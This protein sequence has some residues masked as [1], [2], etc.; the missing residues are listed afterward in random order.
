MFVEF[1]LC[2]MLLKDPNG[3]TLPDLR[4]TLGS[5]YNR[6]SHFPFEDIE[7]ER[8]LKL[9]KVTQLVGSNARMQTQKLLIAALP[10]FW[11]TGTGLMVFE[12]EG[13]CCQP[14]NVVVRFEL[15]IMHTLA[16]T[17]AKKNVAMLVIRQPN[18]GAKH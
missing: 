17:E 13:E 8:A 5:R 1:A 15:E 7:T 9:P 3:P 12:W 14:H 6:Y 4:T 2:Q 16:S 10:R 18:I 11:V